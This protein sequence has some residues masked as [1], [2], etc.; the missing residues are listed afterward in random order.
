MAYIV[1]PNGKKKYVK[2]TAKNYRGANL[3]KLQSL[4]RTH[5]RAGWHAT[6]PDLK[7][8]RAEIKRRK[9]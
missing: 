3:R 2:T 6:K 5:K 8:I 1:L 9:K 4:A 7:L